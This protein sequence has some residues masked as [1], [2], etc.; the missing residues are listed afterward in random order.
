[1]KPPARPR[2]LTPPAQPGKRKET[3]P[4]R[5]G[6]EHARSGDGSRPRPGARDPRRADRASD[7]RSSGK[8]AGQSASTSAAEAASPQPPRGTGARPRVNEDR[9]A[10][11]S[12]HVPLPPGA[13]TTG[14]TSAAQS[15][16]PTQATPRVRDGDGVESAGRGQSTSK[17]SLTVDRASGADTIFTPPTQRASG[18]S[19][20]LTARQDERASALRRRRYLRLAIAAGA[21]AAVASVVWVV[22]FSPVFALVPAQVTV[23]GQGTVIAP[24]AVEKVVDEYEGVPLTRL[25]TVGLRVQILNVP[26]VRDARIARAWPT[27]LAISLVSREPVAAVPDAGS[28]ALVDEDGMQV[29]RA[30]KV[31]KGLPTIKVPL[32]GNNR[33]TLE[34]TLFMINA[35]P[36]KVRAEIA[37]VSAQSPD[38]AQMILRDGS[39]VLWGSTADADL[40]VRVLE[41]LRAAD[42][43]K[44]AKVFDVSAPN[45]P[46]T[47]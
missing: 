2:P 18:V 43:T 38:T 29:G 26:G 20:G 36:D 28:Y 13:P 1:M 7:A 35:I 10:R 17:R 5:D 24:G 23:V 4:Q 41:V 31:P 34:A 22:F 33:R 47:R 30:A 6:Q 40:K 37:S 21:L 16:S 39:K 19:T 46:I 25:D 8:N 44:D 27:G 15:Q 3:P 32:D 45:A 9:P 11:R 14:S 12:G 42:E